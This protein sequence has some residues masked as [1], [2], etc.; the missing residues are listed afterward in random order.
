MKKAA[1]KL[2]TFVMAAAMLIGSVPMSVFAADTNDSSGSNA[3][4]AS[5]GTEMETGKTYAVLIDICSPS[6]ISIAESGS[7][8]T[9]ANFVD[10]VALVKKNDNGTYH[11]TLQ[12][13][14]YD[15]IDI[16]QVSKP[17]AIDDSITPLK[18]SMGTFNVP[19]TYIFSDKADNGVEKATTYMLG[20][21]LVSQENTYLDESWNDKFIQNASVESGLAGRTYYSFDVDNITGSMYVY[22]FYSY[23]RTRKADTQYTSSARKT[24]KIWLKVGERQEIKEINSS[25]YV[26]AGISF[27]KG[28]TN[29]KGSY[30]DAWANAKVSQLFEDATTSVVKDGTVKITAQL[31]SDSAVKSVKELTSIKDLGQSTTTAVDKKFQQYMNLYPTEVS[32]DDG[33]ANY[34]EELL[35]NGKVSFTFE[36]E[37]QAT[38][39]KRVKIELDDGTTYFAEVRAESYAKKAMTLTDE[40]VTLKTDSYSVDPTATLDAGLVKEDTD[41]ES[42]YNLLYSKL[43]GNASK[44]LMYNLAVKVGDKNVTPKNPVELRFQIPDGWDKDK[45]EVYRLN[46]TYQEGAW[47]PINLY[48]DNVSVKIEGNEVVVSDTLSV[49]CTLAIL[50]TSTKVDISEIPDGVYKV[51]VTMWQQD[52]PDRLSMSNSAVVSDSARLEVKNGKKHIYFDTQGITIGGKYGY[53]NGIFWAN[54]EQTEADGLPVLNEYTPLDYYSYY[55]NEAGNTDMDSYAEAYD[56]YYPKTVG[57]EFPESAD[58]DDG[59]YLNFYV[60]IM[61]ELQHK[62][63]GSGEGSRTAFMTLSG[64]ESV[65]EINEPIHDKSVLVVAVDKAS[66]YSS[67]DYTDDSYQVLSDAVAKAQ[68]VIDGTTSAND[69]EIVALDKEISDAIASLKELTGLEKYNRVLAAANA[70]SEADYTAE[71]WSDLQAV[72][73]AQTGNV[74]EENADQAS[75]ELKAAVDALVPMSTAVSLESGVYEVQASFTN[76]DGSANDLSTALK[77]ARL[78]ADK[79][80]NV[81]AYLYTDS[82]SGMQYRKGAGYSDAAA[83]AGRLVI[84]LPA[85]VENHKVKVT[86]ESGEMELLL[87]LDLKAAVKQDI[88]KADLTKKLADAKAYAAENYT[89]DSYAVLTA[90]ITAAEAVQADAAAFQNEIDAAVSG[91][92]SA[93]AGLVVKEEVKARLTLDQALADAK[94]NYAAANY[95]KESY[96]NLQT[97]ISEAEK[98]LDNTASTA[99]ELNAQ[100]EKLQNAVNALVRL[101]DAVDKTKLNG[102]IAD[103]LT[104]VNENN[105][106]TAN[107]WN[108]FQSALKAAQKVA[109]NV[110]ATSEEVEKVTDL[111]TTSYEALVVSQRQSTLFPEYPQIF[112]GTYTV[113]I[114][115]VNA[116]SDEDSM[117]NASVVQTGTVRVSEKGDV[118][119]ELNFQS[120]QFA[121]MTGYLYKLKK[122]DMDTVEYNKYNYPVKYEAADATVLD[123]YKDVYDL[124]NDKTSKF[125]DEN[126]GGNWYPKTVSMPIK[127]NDNLFYVE[128]YVPVMES[129]G[130]GQGTKV[131]RVA[132]DWANIEQKSGVTR[133]NSVLEALFKQ[134][135][136]MEQGN[137]PA[138]YWDALNNAYLTA[139]DVYGDMNATQTDIDRQ[140]KALQAAVDAIDTQVADLD[141]LNALLA[142][143]QKEAD[144]T[145][146]VYTSATM[147]ALKNAIAN[148]QAVAGKENPTKAEVEAAKTAVQ[149]ALDGLRQVDRTNLND[150]I[151]KAKAEAAKTDVYDENSLKVLNSALTIAENVAGNALATEADVQAAENALTAAMNGLVKKAV[152]D[153][154]SLESAIATAKGYLSQTDVYTESSLAALQS[155]INSAQNVMDNASASQTLVDEQVSKLTEAVKALVKKSD[156]ALDIT[157]LADGVYSITGTMVKVDKTSASMSNEAINHTI[158]LT[159]KNGKYYITLNFNG[160]TVGQKLGYLSK[161]KYFTTGYT[162]DKYGNPQGTLADVIVDSY[163]KNSDGS[164]VS[165]TY[166]SNYPDEVTFE[167]IPEALTDGYVPLQVFVPI[168]DAISAGTGTQPVFLKLDWSSLKATTA[169]DPDFDKNDNNN[170]NNGNVNGTISNGSSLGN[171]QLGNNTLGNSSLG[172]S[173]N[174]GSSL[175]SGASSLGSGSGLK[176]ASSV[177]TADMDLNQVRILWAAVIVAAAAMA[178]G[179]AGFFRRR[180]NGEEQ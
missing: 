34:S 74:T 127:L 101:E 82:I 161:L 18:G 85:N 58:R 26:D 80:G 157:K 48:E 111:L 176:S 143:A 29:G 124:F 95:T 62:V 145:D 171:G 83:E 91:L 164:L 3:D 169:D 134:V 27:T 129:I 168:M 105:T 69:S 33:I 84:T 47:N 177:K 15:K 59:V 162:L 125:Y 14:N 44:A 5:T 42:E 41:E 154:S 72:L 123:E 73:T 98:V 119:L 56:L 25:N 172:S 7:T 117:G 37:K 146:V 57:F 180:R 126:T 110:N 17:G 151:T 166:G 78:S 53:S 121:G 96:E 149:T 45:I 155:A 89:E 102:Y 46:G 135:S 86:T 67:D 52:Q 178:F 88:S 97:A 179:F 165:D 12:I 160:L 153:K 54:N 22:G 76:A 108:S 43:A 104:K 141:G 1:K 92:D 75:A 51:N 2:L 10:N 4:V 120:M 133:D 115:L 81:T 32:G 128:V 50:E 170:N 144:R 36:N 94:N 24:G 87:H 100:T 13:E 49:N 158:K 8:G 138:E 55:L 107:S 113:P 93:A 6:G 40:N 30:A 23:G 118:T 28:A 20:K 139:Q 130:E 99:E 132:I 152:V 109:E 159:V 64:L 21:T 19:D 106:Y 148:A 122:V 137:V 16:F 68:N 63:P 150:L 167:L 116:T 163:Q 31:K 79:D 174:S 90:A 173:L 77:S 147:E 103:A 71:S 142:K 11:V 60:P 156:T 35:N 112:A 175:K 39:G 38:F 70:L 66:K 65:L 136:G 61:D 131:A 114:R 9:I 140:V